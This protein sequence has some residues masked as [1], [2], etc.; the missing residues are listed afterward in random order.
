MSLSSISINRP[1]LAIVMSLAILLFGIIG[2]RYLGVREYPGVDKPIITV[3]TNY[4]GA[5]S[6]VI[7]SQI[8][9]PLEESINGIAG[10]RSLT[11]VSRDG[12]STIMVE[13]DL[14]V[15]LENA[16]NDVRDRVSRT[17]MNLPPD[18]DSPVVIKSDADATP[19]LY[20]NIK[21]TKRS[22]LEL[23]DIAERTFKE[24]LQTIPG[25]SEIRIWGQKKYA[26]RLWMDASR[27]AA[28]QLTPLDVQNALLRE[29]I[30]LPSGSIEGNNTE[31][32]VR[33]LGRIETPQEFNDLIIKEEG[34]RVVRF[35]DIGRAELGPEN[36]R[37]ILKKENIPMVGNAIIPQ[38][39]SNHIKIA[40]EFYKRLEQIKKDLP[41]DVTV[42]M[43]FDKTE[44]IKA[45][46][47]EVQQTIFIAFFLVVFIIFFFL[48]DWRTTIIPVIVIP[49]SLVGSFFIMY[50][51]HFSIN[52]LTLLGIVLA[53]GLVVDDAIVVLEN[54]YKKIE[55]G[56]Q[57]VEAG[58]MGIKEIFFAVIATT[59]ALAAVF[60]PVI[61]LQ[62]ITGRLFREFGIVITGAVIISS[63]VALTLT[64][65]LSTRILKRQE[66][67]NW[68][69]RKTDPFFV[70]L[71]NA[72]RN[73]LESFMKRREWA[74]GIIVLFLGLI[75]GIGIVIPSELA[76]L[77]DR[78][79]LSVYVTAPEGSS[80]DYMDVYMN[81]LNTLLIEECPE[82]ES[83]ISV[84]SPDFGASSSV[85]SGFVGVNL[86]KP[87][88]RLKTQQEI[89]DDLSKKIKK[90][91]GAV[92]FVT[93]EQTIGSG[94][95]Q[96]P[97]QYVLQ[98]LNM[99]N[100]REVLPKFFSEVHK[101]PIFN[102]V[103]VDV[104]F[105]KPEL[106]VEI[107]R[108]KA[109]NLNVSTM[110]IAKTLQFALSGQRFGYFIMNGKQYEVI[111]QLKRE[112]RNDPLDLKSLFVRNLDG[113]MIQLDNLV[114]ITEEMSPPRLY[115]YNRYVSATISAGLDKG[116]TIGDGIKAMERIAG[117]VL[118][119]TFSTSL[120]GASKDFVESSSSMFFAFFLALLLIY[121]VLAAQFESFRDPF[122]IMLTVPLAIG[123]A[124]LT[125]W[126]F[127]ETFNIFSQIGIIMLIGLVSKNGI[128]IVEFAN[129]RKVQGLNLM[130]AIIDASVSRFRPILMTSLSTIL[131]TMPIALA[132]G[133]GAES[134][135]SMGI[136][137]IGGLSF[138]T[139][140]TL[141]II[142]AMYSYVSG[143][144]SM[145]MEYPDR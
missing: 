102:R 65:M 47:K 119:N 13:F 22:L 59:I 36:L 64:P 123:G 77:E 144:T 11:S 70:K 128:L 135:I 1:V 69:Y 58:I 76:P 42:D 125:L 43:G 117:N 89:A 112:D 10:I 9:E 57:P 97:V 63:F 111:G 145:E 66:S 136:A 56:I 103:H 51:A 122:I 108:E 39:K 35:R 25:I 110:N 44:Y 74:F 131:G 98:A 78:S 90:L 71:T 67:K 134:R 21:S 100:L 55:A 32:T 20:L 34:G 96:L 121:L 142:P 118:D 4:T 85:N 30:E 37:T 3:S 84:S 139:L 48:R 141:Y 82:R 24:R 23:S 72:Y 14:E 133:A 116:N 99:E 54:I 2:Y 129:Q 50:I 137:L 46:I 126:Y 52:V 80:F 19:I 130:D 127:G 7:E 86:K 8:T 68:F 95:N 140:L 101:E 60:L 132:L 88:E 45:S 107:H 75:F 138:S 33:T 38:P 93:Q 115:R 91:T 41:E 113:D 104:K 94:R 15:D 114:S 53:I 105:N 18:A 26:M 17:V 49:I 12:R 124:V 109:R 73:S 143:K 16:A 106:R 29:N 31:L 120:S 5:N 92:S 61:F 28:Y 6:D 81:R 83:V 27:L 87:G 62:G 79:Y 40:D